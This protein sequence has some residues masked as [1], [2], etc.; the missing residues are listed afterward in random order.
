MLLF[1]LLVAVPL[2]V[3]VQA[4][5]RGTPLTTRPNTFRVAVSVHEVSPAGS[6]TDQPADADA[7]AVVSAAATRAT[8]VSVRA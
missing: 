8:A 5:L 3:A 4:L 6:R 2:G 1:V 7:D